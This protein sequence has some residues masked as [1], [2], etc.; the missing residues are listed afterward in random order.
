MATTI[1]SFKMQMSGFRLYKSKGALEQVK[2]GR[3]VIE[4][5]EPAEL[6]QLIEQWI[7]YIEGCEFLAKFLECDTDRI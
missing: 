7:K 6:E 5:M 4:G 2:T 1:K 3:V